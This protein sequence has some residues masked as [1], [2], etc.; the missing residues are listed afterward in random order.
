MKPK[1]FFVCKAIFI[2]CASVLVAL[3]CLFIFSFILFACKASGAC[4]VSGFGRNGLLTFLVMFPWALVLALFALFLILETLLKKFSLAYKRPI[5]YSITLLAFLIILGGILINKT[6]LHPHLWERAEQ[7][8]LP[9]ARR[10][11]FGLAERNPEQMHFLEIIAT[12][13]DGFLATTHQNQEVSVVITGETKTAQGLQVKDKVIVFGKQEGDIIQAQG[14]KKI[15]D[16]FHIPPLLNR[17]KPVF[18]KI[19]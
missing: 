7:N 15:D 17:P 13:T 16:N 11:Y 2:I 6:P 10:M 5:F 9:F 1:A 12:T 3:F 4:Y 18:P 19:K 14:I 8:R